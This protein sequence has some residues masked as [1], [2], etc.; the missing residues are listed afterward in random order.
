VS[1][2][3]HSGKLG[4]GTIGKYNATTGEAI[5]ANFITGVLNAGFIAVKSPKSR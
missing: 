4:D 3:N 1:N 2:I 5:D